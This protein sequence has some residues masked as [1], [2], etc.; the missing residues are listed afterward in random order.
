MKAI[1]QFTY[2]LGVS[3]NFSPDQI[4]AKMEETFYTGLADVTK[5]EFIRLKIHR[6][7]VRIISNTEDLSLQQN[8][9]N[10]RV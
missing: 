9:G 8:D 10:G 4:Q 7:T 2:K 5:L 6:L 3:E 1:E